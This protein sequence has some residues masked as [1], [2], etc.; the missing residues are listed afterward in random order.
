M[1]RN[2][3]GRP[4]LAARPVLICVFERHLWLQDGGMFM[5]G[6]LT[7]SALEYKVSIS[8]KNDDEA[9]VCGKGQFLCLNSPHWAQK[10]NH[11]PPK[12]VTRKSKRGSGESAESTLSV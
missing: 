1:S 8:W 5:V 11:K 4:S 7:F 3:A 12:P 6:C 2:Q 10:T 9:T